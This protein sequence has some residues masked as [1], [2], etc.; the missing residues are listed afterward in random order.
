[1][2]ILGRIAGFALVGPIGAVGPTEASKRAKKQLAELKKQTAALNAARTARPTFATH[3]QPAVEQAG[4]DLESGLNAAMRRMI[5][6]L[7]HLQGLT[8]VDRYSD[9]GLS[10][11]PYTAEIQTT[12]ELVA[13]CWEDV[14]LEIAV[15]YRRGKPPVIQA[16]DIATTEQPAAV[17][18]VWDHAYVESHNLFCPTR[19]A[20]CFRPEHKG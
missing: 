16:R 17:E 3:E 10:D 12:V 13:A 14:A 4:S 15:Q 18:Q 8:G 1:M 11:D 5:D 19:C 2:G 7:S 6:A 9:S 20:V